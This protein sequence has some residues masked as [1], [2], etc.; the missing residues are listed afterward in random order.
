MEKEVNSREKN[1]SVVCQS[2]PCN[3]MMHG[4]VGKIKK[5]YL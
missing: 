4:T 1:L 5:K 3:I 2:L